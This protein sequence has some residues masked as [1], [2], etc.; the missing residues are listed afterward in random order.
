MHTECFH[1]ILAIVNHASNT[2]KKIK[3]QIKASEFLQTMIFE[4]RCRIIQ[5]FKDLDIKK[6]QQILT[7]YSSPFYHSCAVLG[8]A[9]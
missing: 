6:N 7:A 3:V 1:E 8:L 4:M 9:I 5:A 2:D